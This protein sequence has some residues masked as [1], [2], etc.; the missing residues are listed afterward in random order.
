MSIDLATCTVEELWRLVAAHLEK[1]GI[2]VVLVGGAVVSV[3]SRDAYRSG[4]LDFVRDDLFGRQDIEEVM[5]EIG[6]R[7]RNRHFVHPKCLHLFVEFVSGP[8]GIGEDT[9][10]TPDEVTEDGVTIK[11]LS[12]TDC[13]RDRLCGFIYHGTRDQMDQAVLV[14][15]AHPVDWNKVEQWVERE[16]PGSEEAYAELRRRV[17]NEQ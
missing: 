15:S 4:D 12:P 2:G 9:N 14:A 5:A 13:V 16:A 10:I 7:R 17:S 3:L 1:R 11:I 8:V 6:F